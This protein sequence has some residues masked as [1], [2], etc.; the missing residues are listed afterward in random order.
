MR[1]SKYQK[2]RAAIV[3]KGLTVTYYT[4]K[5]NQIWLQANMCSNLETHSLGLVAKYGTVIGLALNVESAHTHTIHCSTRGRVL[6][7]LPVKVILPS[8]DKGTLECGVSLTSQI[9]RGTQ[10]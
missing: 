3:S 2:G 10:N 8:A 9:G 1:L 4:R 7:T 6:N 5:G